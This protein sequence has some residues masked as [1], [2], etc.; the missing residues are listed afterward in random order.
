MLLYGCEAWSILANCHRK[1]VQ[2]FQNKC[3]KIVFETPRYTRIA[4]LHK[5]ANLTYIE[6]LVEDRVQKMFSNLSV[7]DNS[8]VRKMGKIIHWRA[9]HRGIFRASSR[10]YW[11]YCLPE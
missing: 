6:A 3:L 8:L 2:V 7:H 9:K 11:G 10:G 1:K 4:E 5:V